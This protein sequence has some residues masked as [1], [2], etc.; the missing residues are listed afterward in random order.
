MI[1]K[2]FMPIFAETLS[3]GVQFAPHKKLIDDVDMIDKF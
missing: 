1:K 2:A 3:S